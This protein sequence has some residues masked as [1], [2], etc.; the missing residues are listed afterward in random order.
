MPA[1]R[2]PRP[3]AEKAA[4]GNPGHRPIKQNETAPE[5]V[6]PARGAL[7]VPVPDWLTGE[8]EREIYARVAG[9][10][11]ARRIARKGDLNAYARYAHYLDR[12]VGCKERLN[13]KETF[14][15]SE[16]K[17]GKLLR[18]HPVFKDM[19]D[20]ER[21]LQSLEDRLGLNPVARQ[22]ILRGLMAL[23]AGLAGDL[24]EENEK[25]APA[26]SGEAPDMPDAPPM[27]EAPDEDALGFLKRAAGDVPD[28][29]N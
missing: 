17:H 23:P 21:V 18:R 7:R 9:E 5:H 16:S 13:D 25:P 27:P 19:L 24:F 14:F 12:W 4:L 10:L 8:R 2:P 22:N 29:L 20:L 3:A 11:S 26:A 15:I 28:R 6:E 1:G